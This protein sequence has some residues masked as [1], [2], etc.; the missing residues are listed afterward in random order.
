MIVSAINIQLDQNTALYI[1]LL[2]L[3]SG[4]SNTRGI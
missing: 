2:L 4:R 3:S 1:D